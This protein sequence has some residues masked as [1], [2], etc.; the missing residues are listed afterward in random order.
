MDPNQIERSRLLTPRE[1]SMA[2]F[3]FPSSD[4][5]QALT[6]RRNSTNL[7]AL[8]RTTNPHFKSMTLKTT[9]EEE[10]PKFNLK[11]IIYKSHSKTMCLT[12]SISHR[13]GRMTDR[14]YRLKSELD[15][16]SVSKQNQRFIKTERNITGKWK[17]EF[18]VKVNALDKFAAKKG[19]KL[20]NIS[21]KSLKDL[22]AAEHNA[23][24]NSGIKLSKNKTKTPQNL[25]KI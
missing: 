15:N 17:R 22:E 12:S 11:E 9:M 14:L 1:S 20:S 5:N 8:T 7:P 2:S 10:L 21:T 19:V 25:S 23:L 6:D 13:A 4:K 24:K 18:E 16:L 3:R